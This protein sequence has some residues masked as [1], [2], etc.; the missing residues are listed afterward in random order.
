MDMDYA[1]DLSAR[2][3][4][5]LAHGATVTE[6][7]REVGLDRAYVSRLL[8]GRQVPSSLVTAG[9]IAD[10]CDKRCARSPL[11]EQGK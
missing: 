4:M 3:R 2:L 6:I 7:A 5:A 1:A 9:K 11:R 8:H 10:W